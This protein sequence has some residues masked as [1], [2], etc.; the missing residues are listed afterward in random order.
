MFFDAQA[1]WARLAEGSIQA[2][3]RWSSW[4]SPRGVRGKLS[5]R[6]LFR[7]PNDSCSITAFPEHDVVAFTVPK[8][9][10]L[11]HD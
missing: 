2:G 1:S 9:P 10:P 7:F 5:G 4:F 6:A 8:A 11:A 3:F